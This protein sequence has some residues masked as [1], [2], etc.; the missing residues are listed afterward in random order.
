MATGR[1]PRR[2]WLF[3]S[4]GD[5]R[6][7][8]L[9]LPEPPDAQLRLPAAL[10]P[11]FDRRAAG[12]AIGIDAHPLARGAAQQVV[13]RQPGDLADDVPRRDLDRERCTV[14]SVANRKPRSVDGRSNRLCVPKTQTRTY[15]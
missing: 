9:V 13:D 12:P 1:S 6:L 10:D 3:V 14:A 15:W 11:L 7:L 4:F 2:D 8:V 5:Q